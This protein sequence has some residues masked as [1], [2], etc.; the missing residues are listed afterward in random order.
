MHQYGVRD[1]ERLL[2]LSRS[3]IRALV[4]AGF[5]APQRGP[6]RA[7]RFSF[8]DLIVLRTA[9]ALADA[10]VPSQRI[11]RSMREL[12]RHLPVSMPLSGLRIAAEANRVVV[13]EGR[14]RWRAD[15]GQYLLAFEGDPSSGTLTVL[16]NAAPATSGAA[17]EVED[18][19]D[20]GLELHEK[21]DLVAAE[22]VYRHGLAACGADA[23]LLF[24]LGVL[25]ED[26]KRP[27]DAIGAYQRALQ[28]DP[29]L[30]DCHFNLALVLDAQ[31]MGR[32]AIRHMAQYR[33]LAN[34]K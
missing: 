8:R 31:G 2:R 16:E 20:R 11:T 19:I 25:L 6:R 21:G 33:R 32:D 18:Y 14:K 5:V 3:T 4:Q 30:A 7:W 15:S 24:N 22:A 28:A 29:R 34:R 10:N 17:A 12:R 13:R 26:L 27:S 1:V 23:V 9:Q